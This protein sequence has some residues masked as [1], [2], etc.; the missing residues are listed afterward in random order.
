[1][2]LPQVIPTPT[3]TV[4]SHST[5]SAFTHMQKAPDDEVR[6][7]G[8]IQEEEVVVLKSCILKAPAVVQFPV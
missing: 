7:C 1:M 4:H 5:F 3:F 8:P 2:N 6:G